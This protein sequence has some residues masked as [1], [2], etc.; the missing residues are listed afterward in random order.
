MSDSGI[1]VQQ[2][3][4]PT[5]IQPPSFKRGRNSNHRQP[6][7]RR[8]P[9]RR[10]YRAPKQAASE[11]AKALIA[12]ISDAN[13]QIAAGFRPVSDPGSFKFRDDVNGEVD[14]SYDPEDKY[15]DPTCTSEDCHTHRADL[16]LAF[17]S[18]DESEEDDSDSSVSDDSE[19]GEEVLPPA[20]EA[21]LK[22]FSKRVPGQL[23]FW[24][25]FVLFSFLLLLPTFASTFLY[26]GLS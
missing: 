7:P 5:Q 20:P 8:T 17:D 22:A 19:D 6:C 10:Q 4:Q 21:D 3:D 11:A 25:T 18:D 15:P 24:P 14:L 9:R 26:T 1:D 12:S 2:H 13:A 23:P 16:S